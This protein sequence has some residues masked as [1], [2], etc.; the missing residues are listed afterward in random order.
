MSMNSTCQNSCTCMVFSIARALFHSLFRSSLWFADCCLCFICT[1][2]LWPATL[3]SNILFFLSCVCTME[4]VGINVKVKV[5]FL[6]SDPDMSRFTS[7]E[8]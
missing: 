1:S 7:M 3:F 5:F 4:V 6:E 2:C 8:M